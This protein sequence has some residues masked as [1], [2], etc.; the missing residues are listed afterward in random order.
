MSYD[1]LFKYIIIGDTGVGKS[2][3]LLQ[4]TDKRFQPVH[5]LT[6]G[7]EFGARMV[8]I[9]GKP[10]KL[11]IW[12]TA[13]QESFRSIT[14]S[15]YRG[16]AGALLVYDITRRETF[17]HLASWL[18]DARQHANPNMTIMLVGNKSDLSHRRAVSKE[19]G[20]QFAKENGLL[21]LE[22]SARTA[23]SVEEAFIQTAAKIL[24]KIHEGVFDVSNEVSFSGPEILGVP[25]KE[26]FPMFTQLSFFYPLGMNIIIDAFSN[27]PHLLLLQS[28]GIK[29]GYGRTQGPA[30]PRDGAVA[31]RGGCCS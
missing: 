6:I 3:L 10:I 8:T 9:D 13:G 22:A 20:E 27:I 2:C 16:A 21:F 31:Q 1:Y 19:E 18:E 11:Q 12:D 25:T 14:R 30:G 24:Q 28:S 17:N 23:Q 26:L 5:D 7:V 29:V 15:Y 4:F